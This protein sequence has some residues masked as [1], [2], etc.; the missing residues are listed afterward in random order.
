VGQ[1]FA[2]PPQ[3]SGVWHAQCGAWFVPAPHGLAAVGHGF[4]RHGQVPASPPQVHGVGT[5]GLFP[6]LHF[7]RPQLQG[8]AQGSVPWHGLVHR[9]TV[10]QST[11]SSPDSPHRCMRTGHTDCWLRSCTSHGHS[12]RDMHTLPFPRR[13]RARPGKSRRTHSRLRRNRNQ[14]SC[15]NTDCRRLRRQDHNRTQFRRTR[16]DHSP[17]TAC[18]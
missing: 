9:S 4:A 2:H 16:T 6:V 17:H 12:C 5:H 8:H 11:C 15:P 7:R 3:F 18:R 13:D 1:T 10:S 14:L